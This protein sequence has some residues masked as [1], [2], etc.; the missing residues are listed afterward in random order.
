LKL[1]DELDRWVKCPNAVFVDGSLW[2]PPDPEAEG[3]DIGWL[4]G[5]G[6]KIGEA[7]RHLEHNAKLLPDGA[8][9]EFTA[10][11]G[12]IKEIEKAEASGMEFT[13]QPVPAPK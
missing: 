10:L 12:L 4:V 13:D 5:I 11:A 1:Y 9:C 7:I 2:F 6:D 8:T 3:K